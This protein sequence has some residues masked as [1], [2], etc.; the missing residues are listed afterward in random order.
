MSGRIGILASG[1]AP[2]V[3]AG[4]AGCS[5]PQPSP[6]A[7]ATVSFTNDVIPLFQGSCDQSNAQCHGD[8]TVTVPNPDAGM[9]ARPYLGPSLG[10][11]SASVVSM[12]HDGLVGVKAAEDPTMNLVT[13]LDTTNS[14]LWYKVNDKQD[15]LKAQCTTGVVSPACGLVMPNST[16]NGVPTPLTPSQLG[17]LHDWITEG[18]PP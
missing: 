10:T 13:P 15:T 1:F 7:A 5:S 2:L 4:A 6:P 18:A 16:T 8:P 17:V 12:I 3:L 11:P 14:F 9:V